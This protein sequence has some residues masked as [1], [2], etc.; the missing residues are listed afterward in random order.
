MGGNIFKGKTQPIKKEHIL[1][2]VEKYFADLGRVFPHK[3]DMYNTQKMKFIGSVMKKDL[4]G[5]IDFAIDISSI[6]DKKFS[7]KSLAKWGLNGEEVKAQMLKY[8]KRA[9][10]ATDAEL[11]TRAVMKG[12][13]DKINALSDNI[14]CDEKK[15]GS[16]GIFGFFPQYNEAGEALDYGVQMDWMIGNLEWLEF[17]YYSETYEG[18]V[19]GLHRTQLMLSMFNHYGLSFNHTKGVSNL[20]TKEVLAT[21]P[22]EAVEIL[23][24][25]TKTKLS[26]NTIKNYHKLMAVINKL[27]KKDAKGIIGIYLKILDRTRCDIPTDLQDTWTKRKSELGLTG[28][29]LPEGSMLQE[30]VKFADFI[31]A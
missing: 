2:T 31:G 6:A 7:D 30:S 13:V 15:I 14:Y 28:K 4:S 26:K 25:F 9:K 11:M 10:T 8:K 20:E 27:P 19:K 5:D 16:G 12:I 3:K 24:E 17:S 23:E 18:N 22:K 1:I 29:F 21:N